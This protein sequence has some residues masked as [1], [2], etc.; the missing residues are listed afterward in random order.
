MQVMQEHLLVSLEGEGEAPSPLAGEG[1]DEGA[2][3]SYHIRTLKTSNSLP[4][5]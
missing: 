1:W 2:T 5:H 4:L 3:I